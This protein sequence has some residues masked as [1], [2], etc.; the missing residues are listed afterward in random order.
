MALCCSDSS[1]MEM[2]GVAESNVDEGGSVL[3]PFDSRTSAE[4]DESLSVAEALRCSRCSC[5]SCLSCQKE[6]T[7]IQAFSE[8]PPEVCISTR[9][10][11][12]LCLWFH[13]FCVWVEFELYHHQNWGVMWIP[14]SRTNTPRENIETPS[15]FQTSFLEAMLGE[16]RRLSYLETRYGAFST[17]RRRILLGGYIAWRILRSGTLEGPAGWSFDPSAGGAMT[18]CSPSAL[19]SH[20]SS[21]LLSTG[22]LYQPVLSRTPPS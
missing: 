9:R 8:S 12:T 5:W 7:N 17:F 21:S 20:L 10:V 15:I 6:C 16:F 1:R 3:H 18:N 2:M 11:V 13:C 22:L 4:R 19:T 14:C